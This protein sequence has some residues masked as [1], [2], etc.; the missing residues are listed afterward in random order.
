MQAHMQQE[1]NNFKDP[2]VQHYATP[3]FNEQRDRID[4]VFM[5]LP[6]PEPTK[7][8]LEFAWKSFNSSSNPCFDGT[9]DVLVPGNTTRKVQ[10]LRRGHLVVTNEGKN[11]QVLCVL[12]TR[13]VGP[14]QLVTLPGGL[15][16]TPW[17]PVKHQGT[18][19]FPQD[20]ADPVYRNGHAVYSF[21]LDEGHTMMINGVCCVTLGHHFNEPVVSHHYWGTGLVIEDLKLHQGWDEGFI[22]IQ[23]HIGKSQPSSPILEK[24]LLFQNQREQQK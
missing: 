17:H 5:S 11:A 16:I 18:W 14:T 23:Q 21:L 12:K 2:G 19:K 22:E 15:K 1:C 3:A 9:C 13:L 10:D 24:V 8:V 4:T 6:P 7:N 20:I